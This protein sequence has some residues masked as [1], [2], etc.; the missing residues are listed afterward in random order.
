MPSSFFGINIARS[1]MSTY[2]AWL[3]T[4]GHNVANVKTEGY[5]RQYVDQRATEAISLGT[6]YG[7]VGSGVEARSILSQRDIYFD[8]KYRLANTDY[9]KYE[10]F[11]YYMQSIEDY[12]YAK[13][14]NSGAITNAMDSFFNTI[15][16]LTTD[17]ADSTKRAQAI[18]FA[19]NLTEYI[20]EAAQNLKN[21]QEDVN[22][23]IADTVDQINAYGEEIAS[24]TH[25]IN[26][27][28]VYGSRAND[29]RD[30]RATLIDKLSELADV[31][32]VE[33]EPYDGQGIKQFIVSIDNAILVD[34]NI[35]HK[36]YY[37]ARDTYN[38]MNDIDN[39]YDLR[40]DTGQDFGIHDREL[41]GKLQALFEL[42]DGNNG[43]IFTGTANAV[44]GTQ[45][46]T[47]TDVNEMGSNLLKM[48]IPE[49]NGVITV[50]H[51]EYVYDYFE[52][53]ADAS[54]NF[55]YTFHLTDDTKVGQ[56]VTDGEA[57]VADAVD[58]RG[59]PYYLSQLDEF[60][61][62]FSYRFNEV[63]QQGYDIND[64]L[65]TQMFISR[66]KIDD[67]EYNFSSEFKKNFTY[68][69]KTG[70]MTGGND[71]DLVIKTD[72]LRNNR[73][74]AGY[75]V[76]SYYRMTAL[77]TSIDSAILGDSKLLACSDTPNTGVA[78]G[79]NLEVM[80]KLQ[81]D[82][83]MFRQGQPALFL[84]TLTSTVGIDSQKSI[85]NSDNAKNIRDAVESRRMSKA[86]VDEDE[87]A[88]NLIICQNLLNI[89]YKVLSVMNEVLDKLINGTAL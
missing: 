41:G 17:S 83:K 61:R 3:N 80:S 64:K 51:A 49:Q 34:T 54:G 13:T 74:D 10:T 36:L 31:K 53:E 38:A 52:I 89:Q 56:T 28:E 78:N 14:P 79:K 21:L 40:W 81:S 68:D 67:H 2:N 32:V 73:A 47:V 82:V 15:K 29:L 11:S 48:Q 70:E 18:G 33:K 20:N 6:S 42:R 24:L 4:T 12:L 62:T 65:G 43:E 84:Q 57:Y 44:Q 46:V 63:Q 88:Q 58:Y 59:I 7:M 71:A 25:Q 72:D 76:T 55:T 35:A 60:V 50:N 16:G 30:Q 69:S 1:G 77:T 23:Q 66:D 86:G 37:Q 26:A 45:I 9:G 22:G 75:T 19:R 27:L 87:E 85:D 39:L 8:T 5:S